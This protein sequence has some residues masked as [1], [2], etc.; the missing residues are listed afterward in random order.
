MKEVFAALSSTLTCKASF[1]TVSVAPSCKNNIKQI[2]N[3]R[4]QGRKKGENVL[5]KQRTRHS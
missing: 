2:K 4:G 3:K 1:V 5:L